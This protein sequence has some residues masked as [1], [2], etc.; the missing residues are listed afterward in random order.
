MEWPEGPRFES[1]EKGR[2]GPRLGV[3]LQKREHSGASVKAKILLIVGYGVLAT[4]AH[5]Q[6]LNTYGN[7]GLID[8]PTAET[9]ADGNIAFTYGLVGNSSRATVNFQIAPRVEGSLRYSDINGW[10]G[11]NL[12]RN[13][14]QFD[15]KFKLLDEK[16]APFSLSLGFRD[17]LGSAIYSSE[18]LVATKEVSPGLRVTGGLGWGRLAGERAFDNPIGGTR[19]NAPGGSEQL[20]TANFFKGDDVG[21]FGGVEWQPS[22]SSW[23]LKAEYSSDTYEQETASGQFTR[24]N[25]FNFGVERQLAKG[26]DAGLY[27]IGGNE[28]GLRVSFSADPRIPRTPPDLVN[29]PPPFTPRPADAKGGTSWT[30]NQPLK[31]QMMTALLPAFEAEGLDV[32]SA[33]LAA[34]S[35]DFQI[36]NTRHDRPAKAVGRAARLL[37]LGMPPSVETFNITVVENNLPTATVVVNRSDLERLVDTH[38]AVPESWERFSILNASALEKPTWSAE[39]EGLSYSIG[40]KVPFSLSG[41]AFDFDVVIEA[42]A[43]Y[44]ISPEFSI[45]GEMSQSLL[46]GLQDVTP[47]TGPLQRVRSNFAAYQSDTPVLDRLTADYVTKMSDHLYGRASFGYL[48]RMFGGISGE[49]LW[50]DVNSP[51]S[52]GLEVNYV[53]QRDPNSLLGVNGY[54]VVTGHGSI[55][56]DTG[57]NGVFAQVDAGRYLAGDWG[58]TVTLSRRFENG[59]EVA[60]YVTETSA[61]TSGSTSGSFDKGVRLTIPLGWTVP[62]PTRRTLTVPFSDLAR[63]DG[64][65]LDIS[66]RLYPMVRAV[67]R[68]RLGENWASFWQ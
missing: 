6:T 10:S 34:Q 62:F 56:W 12:D 61:D 68:N 21:F 50:K 32:L 38:E 41:G 64:A 20:N 67:D 14:Q 9:M 8:M 63:D 3:V 66:N 39:P 54:D 52:Y 37:A 18:Y 22:G 65:R 59:W 53:Q 44:Q 58:A 7:T 15:F 33:T 35:A 45:T 11:A 57:W 29:G 16:T 55:Y 48:E 17:F 27:W 2:I 1:K 36:A 26:L 30:Q 19:S 43:S 24:D 25:G 23:R 28:I 42:D 60:G 46:G 13:D 51:I 49:L 31:D 5:A 40:P 47:A 4:S